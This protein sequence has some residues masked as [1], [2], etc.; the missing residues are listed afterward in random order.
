MTKLNSRLVFEFTRSLRAFLNLE[1]GLTRGRVPVT[2][3]I[4][5]LQ[6]KI[7]QLEKRLNQKQKQLDT[8]DQQIKELQEARVR[9]KDSPRLM[10]PDRLVWIFCASRSGST[11]LYNILNDLTTYEA[12]HEPKVGSLFGDFYESNSH[13]RGRHFIL[14]GSRNNWLKP[15]R[16]FILEAATRKFPGTLKGKYLAVKEPGH[17]VGAPIMTEALPESCMIL[18]LRDPRD[19]AASS[20]DARKEGS[21][22]RERRTKAQAKSASGLEEFDQDPNTQ[23]RKTCNNY[24]RQVGKAREAYEAHSGPKTILRYEEMVA[25]TVG[26]LSAAHGELGI[27]LDE[28][29]LARVVEKHSWENIPAEERGAGKFYRR[30]QPGSWKED[31]SQEQID[32]VQEI[33]APILQEFYSHG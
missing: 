3:D 29:E 26:A 11:W 21:W 2:G 7:S 10:S 1:A 32:L 16:S 20:L 15:M 14:G 19:V 30:G 27:P 33:T 28:E 6:E 9:E 5:S 31:L 18:L 8:R 22:F 4:R 24:L 25:D 17:A 13:R 23:L 12:W